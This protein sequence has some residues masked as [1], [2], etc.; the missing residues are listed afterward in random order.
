M[1]F[2]KLAEHIILAIAEFDKGQGCIYTQIN[3]YMQEKGYNDDEL[4]AYCEKLATQGI[5]YYSARRVVGPRKWKTEPISLL[6]EGHQLRRH[7]EQAQQKERQRKN[8]A[9]IG[10]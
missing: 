6:A 9:P 5:I 7:I 8:K 4:R 1:N 10:F 3:R 2:D